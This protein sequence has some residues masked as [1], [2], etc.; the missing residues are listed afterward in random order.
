MALISA[1]SVIGQENY[2]DVYYYVKKQLWRGI[3]IGLILMFFVSK[4]DYHYWSKFALIL[5]IF[6]LIL[7]G[8]CFLGPFKYIVNAS[9]RWLKIGP[10]IF[11][12]SEFLKIT[13]ILFLASMLAKANPNKIKKILAAPFLIYLFS[14]G[15][16]GMLLGAQPSTGTF[17]IL[18]GSSILMYLTIGLSFKQ[19]LVIG[20]TGILLL[21][22][23]VISA[24]YRLDRIKAFLTGEN[25][26][27]GSGYQSRQS[28]IGIGS[29][30]I[31]G[32][33]FGKSVQKYNYLPASHTDAIF[34]IIA[35]EF[36]F[37]GSLILL[38]IYLFF[39]TTGLDIAKESLDNFGKLLSTGLITGI[40]IQAF[41]NIAA[42]CK[43]IPITGIPLPFISYGSS[44]LITNL[45]AVGITLN[46]AKSA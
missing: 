46:I 29:G 12:P 27:L 25:D 34:S 21:G 32:L 28:L 2:Q 1:S 13:Y 11:Q 39:I 14:L 9:H 17:L 6:N 20:L 40:G 30:G 31:W 4:I 37:L 19:F 22:V 3:L 35:E 43:L 15:I 36:G 41:I 5:L 16:I 26:P 18:A 8:L 10:I 38:I 7:V 33:G 23:L 42:M 45:L 44:A 24:D